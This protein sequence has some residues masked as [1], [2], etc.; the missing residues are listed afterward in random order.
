VAYRKATQLDPTYYDAYYNLGL[1]AAEA[2]NLQSALLA[3]EHALAL[4]PDSLDA[5]YN[6]ALVLKQANYFRDSAN[7]LEKLV[8]LGLP[9]ANVKDHSAVSR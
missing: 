1:A 2:G 9:S 3:Y 6:F 5:R 8:P 7:E 4:R